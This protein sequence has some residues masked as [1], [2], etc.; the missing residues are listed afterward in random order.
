[1]ARLALLFATVVWGATFLV[2]ERGIADLPVFHL[3]AYRFSLGALLLAPL[4]W[5]RL[6]RRG[7]RPEWRPLLR[8]GVLIGLVLFAGYSFQTFGLLWTTP[9]RSAFLTGLSVLLVPALGWVAGTLRPRR[10][11]LLGTACAAAGLWA[12]FQPWGGAAV[13]FNRGDALTL[14]CAVSFAAHVLLVDR[15]VRRHPVVPLAIVQFLVVAALSAPALLFEPP[16]ARHFT[17]DAVSAVL[18][19]GVFATALAFACQLYAQRRLGAVETSVVLTL[20]PVAAAAL[21]IAVG[22]EPLSAGLGVGGAL[23]LAGMLATDLG[24]PPPEPPGAAAPRA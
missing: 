15:A 8:D 19:T 22:R 6:R 2:V 4:A 13:A 24:S 3:L 16:A 12:L 20:E 18:I 21:S 10:L 7:R 9:S 1:M 17:A 11:A 14:G 23:I 5:W